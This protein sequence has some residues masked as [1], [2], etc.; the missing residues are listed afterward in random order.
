MTTAT[1]QPTKSMKRQNN[2]FALQFKYV[3]ATN[4]KPARY[5]VTQTNTNQSIFISADFGS[6][7]PFEGI[8][9]IIESLPEVKTYSLII[10]NTPHGYNYYTFAIETE[11]YE[12]PDL[13]Q[14][15]KKHK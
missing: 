7:A 8:N 6:L 10:D 5:K 14:H 15:F 4:T 12:I 9:N 11:G 2:I 3:G 13:L 1:K